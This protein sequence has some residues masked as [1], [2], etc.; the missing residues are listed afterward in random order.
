MYSSRKDVMQLIL[1]IF[2][3]RALLQV[4]QGCILI[5]LLGLI[6][7]LIF[8]IDLFRIRIFLVVV[9]LSYFTIQGYKIYKLSKKEVATRQEIQQRIIA[10]LSIPFFIYLGLIFYFNATV[11]QSIDEY[12]I[13]ETTQKEFQ[14]Q[15]LNIQICDT[16]VPRDI[17]RYLTRIKV[18]DQKGN[19]LAR[20]HYVY[21]QMASEFDPV[22]Y[23]EQGLSY[24]C[25]DENTERYLNLPPSAL[26]WVLARIPFSDPGRFDQIWYYFNPDSLLSPNYKQSKEE[27]K[28]TEEEWRK[29]PPHPAPLEARTPSREELEE[30]EKIKRWV[31]EQEEDYKKK[32]GKYPSRID[33]PN[34][35]LN[36]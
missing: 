33:I 30:L 26:D 31:K 27:S 4:V 14:G 7:N 8:D 20:R 28:R 2:N 16:D 34:D 1:Y 17:H 25:L 36:R 11:E 12:G 6:S 21:K 22:Y 24:F 13:C 10:A 29:N 3:R 19:L 32:H 23:S 18:F 35:L 5:I 9:I 15:V